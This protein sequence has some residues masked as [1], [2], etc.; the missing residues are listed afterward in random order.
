MR[1]FL[2][3]KHLVTV[4]THVFS[5]NC[6]YA[7]QYAN[8]FDFYRLFFQFYQTIDTIIEFTRAQLRDS[9]S[10]KFT[11]FK[12]VLSYACSLMYVVLLVNI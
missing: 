3:I 7:I 11:V 8:K 4:N 5:A 10:I 12:N 6:I 9:T 1:L 2:P